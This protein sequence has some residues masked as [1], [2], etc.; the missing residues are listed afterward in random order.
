MKLFISAFLLA[1]AT[2]NPSVMGECAIVQVIILDQPVTD[3]EGEAVAAAA[4]A[5]SS[6]EDNLRNLR[7]ERRLAPYFCKKACRG[8]KPGYCYI[9]NPACKGYRLLTVG[10]ESSGQS[11]NELECYS[12]GQQSELN[13]IAEK[14]KTFSASAVAT[15]EEGVTECDV[16]ICED[17]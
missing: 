4:N 17:P 11:E 5:L 1:F 7:G 9:V 8:Y 6:G 16:K 12:F 14:D 3:P 10:D 15:V 13:A 2:I